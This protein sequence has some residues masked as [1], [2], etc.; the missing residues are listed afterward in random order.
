MNRAAI[1]AELT[2]AELEAIAAEC[3]A[4]EIPFP[5]WGGASAIARP[6]VLLAWHRL[7]R[8][9]ADTEGVSLSRGREQAAARLDVPLETLRSWRRRWR[10]EAYRNKGAFCT[11]TGGS[12]SGTVELDDRGLLARRIA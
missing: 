6:W 1:E 5:L 3:R 12:A 9:I 10:R 11:M 7:A 4:A 2:D 8:R